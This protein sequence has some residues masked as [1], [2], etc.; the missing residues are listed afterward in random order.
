M[1]I[2][3]RP[4]SLGSSPL[5][6][7]VRVLEHSLKEQMSQGALQRSQ[8]EEAHYLESQA[9]QLLVSHSTTARRIARASAR[10]RAKRALSA[11]TAGGGCGL[12]VG[13][14]SDEVRWRGRAACV[15]VAE[16]R[17][18]GFEPD[19]PRPALAAE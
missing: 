12:T 16:S 4:D 10:P 17:R 15:P 9:R 13:H 2:S 1:G 3:G 5:D 14:A 6:T 8:L 7:Y 18:R 19:L 11:G